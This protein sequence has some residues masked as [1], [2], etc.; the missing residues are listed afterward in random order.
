MI[1]GRL[2]FLKQ[3][4]L[5][6][7][8]I[9]HVHVLVFGFF[10]D[11]D[12]MNFM[13]QLLVKWDLTLWLVQYVYVLSVASF[14][15]RISEIGL[16]RVK[17][18]FVWCCK[19]FLALKR[20]IVSVFLGRTNLIFRVNLSH[21]CVATPL[22]RQAPRSL[23]LG[24]DLYFFALSHQRIFRLVEVNR[25]WV[26]DTVGLASSCY[27]LEGGRRFSLGYVK[28]EVQQVLASRHLGSSKFE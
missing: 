24:Y 1:F 8:K 27:K 3:Q 19:L 20:Q 11:A 2:A 12:W 4:A 10:D 21:T 16:N 13:V 5:T 14:N 22:T 18:N 6:R 26:L 9:A 28:S 23:R 25:D 17:A 15:L 7:I